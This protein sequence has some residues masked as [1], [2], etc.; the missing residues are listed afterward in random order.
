MW[1]GLVQ[2]AFWSRR[3]LFGVPTRLMGS[4]VEGAKSE[5]ATVFW[6]WGAS[7]REAGSAGLTLVA[8]GAEMVLC[9]AQR[10]F[11]ERRKLAVREKKDLR[12]GRVTGIR[13]FGLQRTAP[14]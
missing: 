1:S 8:A 13:R 9:A 14:P 4:A 6:G 7:G 10:R 12:L 2:M 5:E 11:E 3:I